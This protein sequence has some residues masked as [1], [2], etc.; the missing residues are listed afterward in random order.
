MRKLNNNLIKVLAA[1]QGILTLVFVG[2]LFIM[3]ILPTTYFLIIA[4]LVVLLFFLAL[5]LMLFGAKKKSKR[6]LIG[7][8][9]SVIMSAGLAAL[10]FV[11]ISGN[12]TLSG[13]TGPNTQ[14]HTY[15]LVATSNSELKKIKDIDSHKVLYNE[16][17]ADENFNKAKEALL[18]KCP[19]VQFVT[20]N[21]IGEMLDMLYNGKVDAI[22][23]NDAFFGTF[24]E[25]KSNFAN[26]TTTIWS[27]DVEQDVD[28]F[29]KD[30]A[31]TKELFTIYISGIDTTGKV[32][33]VSRSDVNM[34]VTVNPETKQILMTSIPRDYYVT[35]ANKGK[36]DKLTHAGLGGV[37]N[38]VKTIENFMG[39]EINYYARVNFTS[40][41]RIVDALGGV[42]VN[43]PV[44]FT[45][46]HGKYKIVA[47]DNYMDGAKALGF[48]RERYSL[49]AGDN[50]RVKNQQRLLKAMIDKMISPTIITNYNQILNAIDG[51]FETNM[52]ND[53]II[54]LIKMQLTDMASWEFK[55]ISLEATGQK[56]YGGALMPDSYLYY[57]I[58]VESSVQECANLIKQMMNGE[59]I[60]SPEQ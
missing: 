27:F 46:L 12:N 34:L 42:T 60:I 43:S 39:I 53:D 25:L 29:S 2:Y 52:S 49:A 37:E 17:F 4:V 22:L 23:V 38:S 14:T 9:F 45:T 19:N 54:S 58:P 21:D 20:T 47:G 59:D 11:L 15:A 41:V 24:E 1:L 31:V 18:K 10:L 55:S 57:A 32:S 56:M 28:D 44:A 6:G 16:E 35:L 26:D 36:K 30:T 50:D 8:V 3:N 33:K 7:K 48:V 5:V 13:I 40:I 51:S